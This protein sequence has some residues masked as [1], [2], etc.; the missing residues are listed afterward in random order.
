MKPE[1]QYKVDLMHAKQSAFKKKVSASIN[2]IESCVSNNMYVAV[3]GGKDSTVMLDLVR[4]VI[5]TAPA[6]FSDDEWM[7]PETESYVLGVKNL[8]RIASPARHSYFFTSNTKKRDGIKWIN[9]AV[10]N[11]MQVYAK[12]QS[13]NCAMIGLRKDESQKRR[14]HI[15]ALGNKFTTKSGVVQCYPIASWTTNDIWAYIRSSG[16]EYNK[17]YNKMESM[18][19]PRKEQRVGPFAVEAVLGY[20]QLVVIKKGWPDLYNR[21]AAEFPEAREWI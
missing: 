6:V 10:N 19:L 20:G 4:R 1:I 2:L 16:I 21:F 15:N 9:D 5:P 12:Q 14:T 8:V 18:G 13:Y 11:S 3:S 17:A 7:F